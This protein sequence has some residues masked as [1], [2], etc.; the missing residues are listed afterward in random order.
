MNGTNKTTDTKSPA[1]RKPYAPPRL[2]SYGH[3]KDIV[4][5]SSG[6]KG[7]AGSTKSC[8][9]AEAL[10]G[11]DD[12]RTILLRSW[13]TA[14]H[15]AR[16]RGWMFVELYRRCGPTVASLIR[17]GRLR[18]GAFLPLFDRLA[19]KAFDVSARTIINARHCRTV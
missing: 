9:I 10:Y 16:Q 14:I 12:P 18:R 13:L 17:N 6:A 5:G 11:A 15:D 3:V 8:W 1:G 4:Q 2:I 7:D 19:V